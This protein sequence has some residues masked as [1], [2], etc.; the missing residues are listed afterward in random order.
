MAEFIHA[1]FRQEATTTLQRRLTSRMIQGDLRPFK[2]DAGPFKWSRLRWRLLIFRMSSCFGSISG[3]WLCKFTI[4]NGY[5]GRAAYH[6]NNNVLFSRLLKRLCIPEEDPEFL[7]AQK[8]KV[9]ERIDS[10]TVT[11]KSQEVLV[12]PDTETAPIFNDYVMEHWSSPSWNGN[13]KFS[14]PKFYEQYGGPQEN[15]RL[16]TQNQKDTG[17]KYNIGFKKVDHDVTTKHSVGRILC[18][19][20]LDSVRIDCYWGNPDV[21]DVITNSQ[22]T[23]A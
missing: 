3:E 9:R 5:V 13:I 22:V 21:F 17:L 12:W 2:H 10:T 18:L 15:R 1:S 11:W 20:G 14:T 6:D 4:V 7:E 19:K 16:L 23:N 8:K